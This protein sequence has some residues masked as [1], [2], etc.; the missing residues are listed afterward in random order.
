LAVPSIAGKPLAEA[1]KAPTKWPRGFTAVGESGFHRTLPKEG[2]QSV[3]WKGILTF[4]M[5]G[6]IG[7]VKCPADNDKNPAGFYESVIQKVYTGGWCKIWM[8]GAGHANEHGVH[9]DLRDYAKVSKIHFSNRPGECKGLVEAL[10]NGQKKDKK[11]FDPMPEVMTEDEEQDGEGDSS[12][13]DAE[14]EDFNGGGGDASSDASEEPSGKKQKIKRVRD[15]SEESEGGGYRE[16]VESSDDEEEAPP[17]K[18]QAKKGKKMSG[19]D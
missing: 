4:P 9:P 1:A 7:L 13:G 5:V 2:Y 16:G 14:G 10:Q 18:K 8:L 3:A 12:E 15:E 17:V 11:P 6:W 19:R